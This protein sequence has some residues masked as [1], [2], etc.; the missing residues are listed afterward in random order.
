MAF[1]IE[2]RTS[3]GRTVIRPCGEV[4]A[5][6]AAGLAERMRICMGPEAGDILVDLSRTAS[7]DSHTLGV[8]VYWWKALK[9]EGREF[10]LVCPGKAVTEK[11]HRTGLDQVL[12]IH[13]DIDAWGQA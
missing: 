6:N 8:F 2:T 11:L 13:D 4:D 12:R 3:N 9:E 1:A 5:R 7:I 10:S